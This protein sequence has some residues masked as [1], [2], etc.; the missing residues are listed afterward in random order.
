MHGRPAVCVNPIS[1][2]TQGRRRTAGVCVCV[3]LMELF[4]S[5]NH[6]EKNKVNLTVSST[7]CACRLN[8]AS[9]FSFYSTN[10]NSIKSLRIHFH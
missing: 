7:A 2:E 6:L 1:N 9:L 10:K 8:A 4:I 5:H 3:F